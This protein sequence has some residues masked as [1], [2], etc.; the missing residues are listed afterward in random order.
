MRPLPAV[1]LAL[2]L[3]ACDSQL[4]SDPAP[5]AAPAPPPTDPIV[6]TQM[7]VHFAKGAAVQDA[8]IRGDV[9]RARTGFEALAEHAMVSGLPEGTG[10]LVEGFQG[11]AREGA[12]AVDTSALAR[13][14]AS[15]ARA[16]GGCHALV[17]A[18]P[19]WDVPDA[20]PRDP[21]MRA[22][23]ARHAWAMDRMYEGLVGPTEASWSQAA[24]I[25]NDQALDEAVLPAGQALSP[26]AEAAGRRL[27]ALGTEALAAE[28]A[29]ARG[30]LFAEALSTCATCH[31]AVGMKPA[32]P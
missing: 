15:T 24:A 5:V 17:G 3:V 1:T 19:A 6:K 28:T 16:C 20:P 2:A 25:L 21:G 14:L 30:E 11:A 31:A 13:A 12:A 23:M 4:R 32:S 10:P 9:A 29:E 8:I 22:H 26:V 7:K 18:R 27:H